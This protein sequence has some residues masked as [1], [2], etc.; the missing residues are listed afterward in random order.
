[1]D[2]FQKTIEKLYSQNSLTEQLD[3]SQ[4]LD[5]VQGAKNLAMQG[6]R[7]VGKAIKK[8]P[9]LLGITDKDLLA[10]A[11]DGIDAFNNHTL[12]K[13][14]EQFKKIK[15]TRYY[16][17]GAPKINDLVYIQFKL[18]ENILVKGPQPDDNIFKGYGVFKAK[19]KLDD[20]VPEAYE[21]SIFKENGNIPEE[22]T[23]IFLDFDITVS[24]GGGTL[25]VYTKY[26]SNVK[27]TGVA[28]IYKQGFQGIHDSVSFDDMY[29]DFLV[30]AADHTLFNS[31]LKPEEFA[32]KFKAKSEEDKKDFIKLLLG[33]VK[34]ESGADAGQK[35]LPKLLKI[36]FLRNDKSK[37]QLASDI[38]II[39]D[40]I[41]DSYKQEVK[42]KFKEALSTIFGKKKSTK[43]SKNSTI[44]KK[45]HKFT[46]AIDSETKRLEDREEQPKLGYNKDQQSLP[47][48]D[49][50]RY[51]GNASYSYNQ[52]PNNVPKDIPEKFRGQ[53]KWQVIEDARF[54]KDY[55]SASAKSADYLVDK[56]VNFE[57][58]GYPYNKANLFNLNKEFKQIESGLNDLRNLFTNNKYY[59]KNYRLVSS[60][61][62]SYLKDNNYRNFYK[63]LNMT[64]KDRI[65][66]VYKFVASLA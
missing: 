42:N 27:A 6:L 66:E 54:A 10:R 32:E 35:F 50:D 63:L 65:D 33:I 44:V 37:S 52:K 57:K 22:I 46:D 48:I 59:Y 11:A 43:N 23:K 4:E 51:K 49:Y 58:H 39:I 5:P 7:G 19:K 9:G 20:K 25:Y 1:M 15:K 21:I 26:K 29:M 28:V 47:G 64:P 53:L 60:A 62:E 38:L 56:I 12:G 17:D 36:L 16:P 14:L 30:E 61:I 13:W 55:Q 31:M 45:G 34:T 2:K 41:P 3:F 24:T 18:E 8:V 40:A